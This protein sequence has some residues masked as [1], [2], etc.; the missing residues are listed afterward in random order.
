[1]I[2]IAHTFMVNPTNKMSNH[3]ALAVITRQVVIIILAILTESEADDDELLPLLS[4]SDS[5]SVWCLRLAIVWLRS[6]W[7]ATFSRI[8]SP[9]GGDGDFL[10]K[11]YGKSNRAKKV[12]TRR[13]SE[14]K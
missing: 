9:L 3:E 8:A 2:P 12:S 6:P 5:I 7:A 13:Y 10:R 4:E 11:F 1:M 14:S